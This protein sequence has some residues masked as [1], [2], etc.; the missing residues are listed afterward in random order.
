MI[1]TN[2]QDLGHNRINDQAFKRFGAFLGAIF[3]VRKAIPI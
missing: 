3:I 2:T 1:R